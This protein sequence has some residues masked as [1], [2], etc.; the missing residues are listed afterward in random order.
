MPALAPLARLV[1]LSKR[2]FL[3]AHLALVRIGLV[4]G[5]AAL[6]WLAALGLWLWALPALQAQLQA[7]R[8]A[9]AELR[10]S[11]QAPVVPQ[12]RATPR[13]DASERLKAFYENLGETDYAEQQVKTIFALAA[14]NGLVLAQAD[15]R[16]A[17]DTAGHFN[18]YQIRLPVKGPYQAVRR[19]CMQM[20]LA[21][22]F[23]SLD[24][25]HFRRSLAASDVIEVNLQLT[26]YLTPLARGGA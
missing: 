25:L 13:S 19:F 24:E 20:L 14:A 2:I 12:A 9:T 23:A 18:T 22:P 10:K 21:M 3:Q 5:L 11:L 17:T 15:Y 6:F 7:Q 16:L 8:V 26:L 1:P 4:N